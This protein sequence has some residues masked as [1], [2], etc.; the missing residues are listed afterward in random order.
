MPEFDFATAFAGGLMIG[1]AVVLLMLFHGRVAGMS[2]IL[3]GTLFPAGFGDWAWRFAFL[4]GAVIAPA[5]LATLG[6][7]AIPFQSPMPL[8]LLV[9][10]GFV[11]GIGVTLGSGCTSGH[12]I[13]GIARFSKRSIAATLVFMT[14]A[15][16]TVFI[17]RHVIGV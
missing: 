9:A 7:Y 13:C 1:T 2:G 11:A 15:A 14:T 10:G 12:G 5:L 8:P 6:G 17:T 3:A 4:L 16:V